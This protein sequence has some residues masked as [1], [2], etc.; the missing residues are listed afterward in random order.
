MYQEPS[1]L[2]DKTEE[3]FPVGDAAILPQPRNREEEQI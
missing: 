2:K 3:R 1:V